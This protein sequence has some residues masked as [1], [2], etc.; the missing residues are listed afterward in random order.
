MT[1]KTSRELRA[2]Y[3]AQLEAQAQEQQERARQRR[4]AT[5]RQKKDRG[6]VT[7]TVEVRQG[8]RDLIDEMIRPALQTMNTLPANNANTATFITEIGAACDAY[9]TATEAEL[10]KETLRAKRGGAAATGMATPV[11]SVPPAGDAKG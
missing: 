4:A 2:A 5:A 1:N 8:Y 11:G 3:L 9:F 6:L 7:L 10:V